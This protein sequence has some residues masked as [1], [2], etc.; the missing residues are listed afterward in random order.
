MSLSQRKAKILGKIPPKPLLAAIGISALLFG[1]SKSIHG[2][3]NFPDLSG[4]TFDLNPASDLGPN[5][6]MPVVISLI[7]LGSGLWVILS[8]RYVAT[9]R[10]WAYGVIGTIVGFWLHTS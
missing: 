6:Y 4:E 2:L 8:K 1:L 7:L 9:D 5:S 10:H 3:A